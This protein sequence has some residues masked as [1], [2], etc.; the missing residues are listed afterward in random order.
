MYTTDLSAEASADRH[1]GGRCGHVRRSPCGEG[2]SGS[3]P[4]AWGAKATIMVAPAPQKIAPK[5]SNSLVYTPLRVNNRV[6]FAP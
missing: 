4:R 3:S 1:S 6:R 5:L 2:G